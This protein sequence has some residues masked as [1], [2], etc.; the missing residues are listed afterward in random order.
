MDMRHRLTTATDRQRFGA[1]GSSG[2]GST[3]GGPDCLLRS[4]V[5]RPFIQ[6]TI[7]SG[8]APEGE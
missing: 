1:L 4:L 5:P 2:M 3:A 8:Y 7:R 6:N